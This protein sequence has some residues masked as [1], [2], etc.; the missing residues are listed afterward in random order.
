MDGLKSKKVFGV[1]LDVFEGEKAFMF[2]DMTKTGYENYPELAD[3][4]SMSNV[5]ISSHIA[6]Y[7]DEAIRQISQK[8]LENYEGFTGKATLDESA[9]VA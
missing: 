4:A 6:F 1:A 5:I 9:F 2:K 3:L 8:T 7:T